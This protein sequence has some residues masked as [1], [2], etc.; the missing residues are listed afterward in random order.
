[1][2]V[3]CV[4]WDWLLFMP[5]SL[6]CSVFAFVGSEEYRYTGLGLRA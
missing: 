6:W 4:L 1:M 2:E 5:L 3:Y